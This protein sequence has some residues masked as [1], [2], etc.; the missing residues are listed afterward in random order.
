MSE[1]VTI[2]Y[3]GIFSQSTMFIQINIFYGRFVQ[4][5]MA[6]GV[7]RLTQ[8]IKNAFFSLKISFFEANLLAKVLDKKQ[9]K[10]RFFQQ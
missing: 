1:K 10:L 4:T 7:T 8:R 5:Q 6:L 3:K 2:S 9:K